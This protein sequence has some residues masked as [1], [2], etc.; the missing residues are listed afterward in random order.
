[1]DIITSFSFVVFSSVEKQQNLSS[2]LGIS[3][4]FTIWV[5]SGDSFH[6]GK[7]LDE[8][9]PRLSFSSIKFFF[10][11]VFLDQFFLRSSFSS[12]KFFFTQVFLDQFFLRSSFSSVK[13]FLLHFYHIYKYCFQL[14][15]DSYEPDENEGWTPQQIKRQEVKIYFSFFFY[16]FTVFVV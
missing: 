10:S 5:L 11:Q 13:F 15:V 14:W 3:R 6:H 7:T 8:Y 4:Q 1:M 12:I 16:L 2:K 9:F